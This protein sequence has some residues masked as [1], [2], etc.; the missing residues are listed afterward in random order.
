[1]DSGQIQSQTKLDKV[2]ILT[3]VYAKAKIAMRK[4]IRVRRSVTFLIAALVLWA[5]VQL[6]LAFVR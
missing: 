3:E 2:S 4:F 5:V 1:M 6:L